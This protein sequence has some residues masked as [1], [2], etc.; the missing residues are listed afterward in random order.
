MKIRKLFNGYNIFTRMYLQNCKKF[1]KVEVR[2]RKTSDRLSGAI[3]RFQEYER[4]IEERNEKQKFK[5]EKEQ[6]RKEKREKR[7]EQTVS[8]QA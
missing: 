5:R 2:V 3:R 4:K 6:I 7:I 1:P 8:D